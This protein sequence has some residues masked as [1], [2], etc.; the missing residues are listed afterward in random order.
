MIYHLPNVNDFQFLYY[1]LYSSQL[2]SVFDVISLSVMIRIRHIM[3][4]HKYYKPSVLYVSTN[5]LLSDIN[6]FANTMLLTAYFL[7]K[8]ERCYGQNIEIVLLLFFYY[9]YF[10]VFYT[11]YS[12]FSFEIVCAI[13][14]LETTQCFL[15]CDQSLCCLFELRAKSNNFQGNNWN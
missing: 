10:T 6:L 11:V 2:W 14:C 4:D 13:L 9:R 15:T 12:F 8:L 3:N 5:L 1:F 7:F